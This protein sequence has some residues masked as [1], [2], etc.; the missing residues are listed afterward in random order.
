MIPIIF[1]GDT[2]ISLIVLNK[3]TTANIIGKNTPGFLLLSRDS[4]ICSEIRQ[5]TDIPMMSMGII[6]ISHDK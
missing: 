3:D 6:L 4:S 5:I 2:K 1:G